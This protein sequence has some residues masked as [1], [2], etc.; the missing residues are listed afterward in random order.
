MTVDDFP[1]AD[2]DRLA[3]LAHAGAL[4]AAEAL[5][6]L[7]GHPVRTDAPVIRTGGARPAPG[8]QPSTRDRAATGV[9]FEFEGCLDAIIG[10]LFPGEANEHLVRSIVGIETGDLEE[11]ILESALM[12][13]GNI[14][15]SHV[16]SAIAN[17]LQARLLPSI[18]SL[19]MADSEAELEVFVARAVGREAPHIESR[20]SHE[21]GRLIGRLV[22][23]P[24][25]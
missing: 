25:R 18:P 4:Q 22:L 8:A 24:T 14:L 11:P 19:A 13:V 9:F 2:I 7:V 12:E 23:V 21:D 16:A 10:V 5:A 3:E 6:Q 1:K 20:L 17:R 15:A